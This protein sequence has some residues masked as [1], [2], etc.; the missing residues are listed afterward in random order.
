ME[1]AN[2][3]V[4][5]LFIP[6]VPLEMFCCRQLRPFLDN[7]IIRLFDAA[8]YYSLGHEKK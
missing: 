3:K 1:S 7:K 4:T 8:K 5:L 6:F 2:I